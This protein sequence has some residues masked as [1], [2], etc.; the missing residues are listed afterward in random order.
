M[1]LIKGHENNAVF[2]FYFK[3]GKMALLCTSLCRLRQEDH[4]LWSTQGTVTRSCFKTPLL[5]FLMHDCERV[6]TLRSP[7]HARV[8]R[9]QIQCLL[10]FRQALDVQS[11]PACMW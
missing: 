3:L 1:P 9:K 8:L 10:S 11:Y 6:L 7:S 5:W 4:K 2:E